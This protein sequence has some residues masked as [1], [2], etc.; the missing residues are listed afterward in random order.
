M[1]IRNKSIPMVII[2]SLVTCGI[3]YYVWMYQTSEEINNSLGDTQE[4]SGLEILLTIITCGI[5][6][7]YWLYKYNHK[8][9]RLATNMGKPVSDN[10]VICIVLA[11]FG[12]MIVS[13]GIMQSQINFLAGDPTQQ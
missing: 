9:L 10:S 8:I 5:Y 11:I 2:L 1:Y 12:F 6:G 3:Y 7:L 4:N 13:Q